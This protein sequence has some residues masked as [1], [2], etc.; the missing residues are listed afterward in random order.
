MKKKRLVAELSR[1]WIPSLCFK[2]AAQPT[3]LHRSLV[4]LGKSEQTVG[5]IHPQNGAIS[6]RSHTPAALNLFK[7]NSFSLSKL[8]HFAN[9]FGLFRSRKQQILSF[10]FLPP[11]QWR[12]LSNLP[13]N[14]D[15]FPCRFRIVLAEISSILC[16]HINTALI[17][18]GLSEWMITF[19]GTKE[20]WNCFYVIFKDE[21]CPVQITVCLIAFSVLTFTLR[22]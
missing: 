19:V 18:L 13:L 12:P 16:F 20:L 21:E 22:K 9:C 17:L 6:A 14:G 10:Y 5:E 7:M 2:V 1:E 8:K 15:A 11:F 4:G 3:R